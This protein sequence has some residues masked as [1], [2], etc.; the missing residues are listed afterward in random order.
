MSA[1][2]ELL[3]LREVRRIEAGWGLSL[4]GN[5][6]ATVALVVYAYA[7]GGAALVAV[8]GVVRTLPGAVVVPVITA[9]A[10][11]I[12]IGRLLRTVTSVRGA[13]LAGAAAVAGLDGPPAAVIALAGVEAALAGSFRPVQAAAL[14]WLVRTPAELTAANV[15][16]TVMEN[17]ASLLGPVLAGVVLLVAG[18]ATSIAVGAGCLA[19]AALSLLRLTV[20]D[21]SMPATAG[22]AEPAPT[23]GSA[24]RSFLRIGSPA[25]LAVLSFTQTFLRGAV[26]VLIVVLAVDVL[27][28]GEDA[29]GW[30]TAAIGLGGLV[31][32]ALAA[33]TV[34]IT[35]LGRAY[36]VGNVLW[37]L[38]LL[39]LAI[40]PSPAAA[41]AALAV[42]GIGNAIGDA[43]MFT[44]LPRVVG[45]RLASRVLGVL[46]LVAFTGVGVGSA[47]AP[48]LIDALG[49]RGTLAVLGGAM[50]ALALAYAAAFARLDRT[51]PPPGPEL[52]LL[53]SLPMFG[54]LPLV[55]VEQLAAELER[56]DYAPGQVVI[57]EGD[58][59]DVFHI[60]VTG[61]TEVS[62]DGARRPDLGP[63]EGFGEIALLR[64]VPRTATVTAAE[65]LRTVTLSRSA[66]LAAV[67]GNRDSLSSALA[68]AE[69][70]LDQDRAPES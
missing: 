2:R 13:V 33:A 66:F 29:V 25:G 1:V 53:R 36:V 65:A 68:V 7:E 20:P 48:V 51:T 70:R 21:R 64:H 37:G 35:R 43:S 28:L 63:G 23:V 47:L 69:R 8:Y 56:R 50:T 44:L 31:G 61:T 59:G 32:A 19:A 45:P 5:L 49:A 46:E 58:P 18:P 27:A 62:S 3:R 52:D 34:R 10:D 24:V 26:F 9:L 39:M 4:A 17:S 38:P 15:S 12:G 6:A 57:R 22:T 55:T 16:A 41:Y 60:I 42:V 11:R 30:L 67:N 40:D 14:P 54:P